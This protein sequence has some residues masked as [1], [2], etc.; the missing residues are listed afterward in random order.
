MTPSPTTPSVVGVESTNAPRGAS[1]GTE[2]AQA[3]REEAS[4]LRRFMRL[5]RLTRDVDEAQRADEAR[6]RLELQLRLD[7]I[8]YRS[9][10]AAGG[11]RAA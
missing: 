6:L 5:A 10:P 9:L 1:E 2:M 4:S 11:W 3:D 7:S 8:R